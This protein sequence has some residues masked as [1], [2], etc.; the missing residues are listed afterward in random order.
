MF[1]NIANLFFPAVC[2]ALPPLDLGD[3]YRGPLV[4]DVP[5]LFVSGTLDSNA[6]PYQAEQ[7]RFGMPRATHIVVANAGHEDMLPAAGVQAAMADF[8]AG[9][10]VSAR[11]IALPPPRF[12][13]ID[14]ARKDRKR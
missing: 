5:V 10:D 14:E 13:S 3:A 9:R 7:L 4:S 6:P 2:S 8:F 1:R 12:L 11:H